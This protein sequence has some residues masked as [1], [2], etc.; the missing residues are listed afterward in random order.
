MPVKVRPTT[1][2]RL[3][4]FACPHCRRLNTVKVY[5]V[6]DLSTLAPRTLV[7]P[8][9]SES[10]TEV[11]MGPVVEGP[12]RKT[13]H[14]HKAPRRQTS[15]EYRAFTVN[16]QSV[17]ADA[18]TATLMLRLGASENSIRS[19]WR[20][21]AIARKT[22]GLVSSRDLSWTLRMTIL[23]LKEA[24]DT[25][26]R[27]KFA[28]VSENARRGGALESEIKEIAM[29]LETAPRSFYSRI[30]NRAGDWITPHSD[31]LSFDDWSKGVSSE[32]MVWMV[33]ERERESSTVHVAAAAA[34]IKSIV[35]NGTSDELNLCV[36]EVI[37]CASVLVRV[38]QCAIA[39]FLS[40]HGVE[41]LPLQGP[42]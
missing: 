34:A 36:V 31:H 33:R 14:V 41:D 35:P 20:M 26:L 15:A 9:C 13:M 39:G 27:P 11:L 7:C 24:T 40:R 23:E 32:S 28:L 4:T 17:S 19:A 10:F 21:L 42:E 25:L 5:R 16:K 8:S 38:F 29:M 3:L 12:I 1:F 22:E 18:E 37:E 2:T 6:I 30:L